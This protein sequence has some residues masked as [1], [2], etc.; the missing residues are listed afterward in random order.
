MFVC[1]LRSL[2]LLDNAL[3]E[4]HAI[5]AGQVLGYLLWDRSI[6]YRS[7]KHIK[8]GF[9]KTL[10]SFFLLSTEKFILVIILIWIFW[11]A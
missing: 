7:I 5:S 8:K 9:N 10:V 11:D 1:P 6:S 3:S 4:K 2:S